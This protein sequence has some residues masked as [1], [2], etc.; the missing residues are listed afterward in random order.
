MNAKP[1]KYWQLLEELGIGYFSGVQV[2]SSS[3][4]CEQLI[5]EG[6]SVS[7]VCPS[8]SKTVASEPTRCDDFGY[9][10]GWAR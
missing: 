7:I 4:Q 3:I 10:N 9:T 8:L 6:V 5:E 1:S 2:A